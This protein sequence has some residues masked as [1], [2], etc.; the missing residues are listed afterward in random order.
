MDCAFPLPGRTFVAEVASGYVPA[1]PTPIRHIGSATAKS[2]RQ[3]AGAV[4][5]RAVARDH[6][7]G[8]PE[9]RSGSGH[10][11]REGWRSVVPTAGSG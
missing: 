6:R 10:P 1:V 3:R 8:N 7:D 2:V 11:L 4:M 9:G 5:K